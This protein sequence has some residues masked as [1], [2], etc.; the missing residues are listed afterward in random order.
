MQKT[1][2]K[3]YLRIT[4]L[5]ILISFFF[6]SL[7]MVAFISGYWQTEK[8]DL[9]QK[10]A[11]SVAVVAAESVQSYQDNEYIICLLYTSRCV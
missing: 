8:H 10:N 1:L 5:I 7:V 3:K 2:F 4:S 9:L 6:L 11:E